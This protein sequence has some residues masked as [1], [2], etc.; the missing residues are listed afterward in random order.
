MKIKGKLLGESEK[1]LLVEIHEDDNDELAGKTIWFPKS[2]I[3]LI[4]DY[5]EL[6]VDK[7]IYDQKVIVSDSGK[8]QPK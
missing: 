6:D 5:I 8:T 3:R 4:A 7:W 1:A 2:K